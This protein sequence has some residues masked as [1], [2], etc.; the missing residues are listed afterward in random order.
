MTLEIG[1]QLLQILEY[2]HSRNPQIFHR[3][4]KPQNIKASK[5]GRVFLLDFGIAK[6]VG[7]GTILRGHSPY[8]SPPE[9]FQG[10]TTDARADLYALG[11]TLYHLVTGHR[12]EDAIT[13]R[14]R[15]IDRQQ[16]DP[17][18]PIESFNEH[19]PKKIAEIIRKAMALKPEERPA[20]AK[21]MLDN[22]N[23]E[24]T[25]AVSEKTIIT[26]RA[27][28]TMVD[29]PSPK[30]STSK[31]RRNKRAQLKVYHFWEKSVSVTYSPRSLVSP[32]E[33]GPESLWLKIKNAKSYILVVTDTDFDPVLNSGKVYLSKSY[34]GNYGVGAFDIALDDLPGR[35]ELHVV[36]EGSGDWESDTIVREGGVV[37]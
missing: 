21:E 15:A 20:S 35:F 29:A 32:T 9:Q 5:A 37:K 4:I 34:E 17:L 12:P 36:D 6:D 24:W 11:A 23:L 26:S 28:T 3:D 31:M 8:Y 18:Q 14:S 27:T 1:S 30:V 13:E 7:K 16:Q 2:L 25:N 33:I 22:L 10:L 19:V